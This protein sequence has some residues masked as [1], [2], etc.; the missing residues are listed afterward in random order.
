[1]SAKEFHDMIIYCQ[2]CSSTKIQN[3]PQ[4]WIRQSCGGR[5]QINKKG[6]LRCSCHHQ[7]QKLIVHWS[8]S[9]LKDRHESDFQKLDTLAV[10]DA[11]NFL[12]S[13]T[14]DKA[15]RVFWVEIQEAITEQLERK[16]LENNE[17]KDKELKRLKAPRRRVINITSEEPTK[18]NEGQKHVVI[19]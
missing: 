11:I 10:L 14:K 7:F 19:K 16:H 17:A 2:V 8:F 12:V 6:M 4:P 15:T 13:A 18:N 3:D 5:I 9:C 1:M